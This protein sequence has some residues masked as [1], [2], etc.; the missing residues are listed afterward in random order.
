MYKACLVNG[1]ITVN[2][3]S[4]WR[5]ILD[6][7]DAVSGYL[8]A[9]QAD[10]SISGVFNIAS[11]NYTVGQVGD[12]V[13]EEVEQLTGKK[14]GMEIKNIQDFR[15]YKVS[16]QKAK[17]ILSYEPKYTVT[18]MI[19]SLH[20]HRDEYADFEDDSYYNIRTF[21]KLKL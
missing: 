10:G 20:K 2:N 7:R 8:R 16:W 3:A 18:D 11:D 13:K 6:I 17:T 1:K 15:N 9:I 5:P 14:V 21:K 19:A 12:L 4:I